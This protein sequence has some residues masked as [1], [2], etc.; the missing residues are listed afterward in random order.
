MYLHTT[1]IYKTLY[2]HIHIHT[3]TYT[4]THIYISVFFSL[5]DQKWGW[6]RRENVRVCVWVSVCVGTDYRRIQIFLCNN[7][8]CKLTVE[9]L[10]I[11]KGENHIERKVSLILSSIV[12]TRRY[13]P[14]QTWQTTL[15]VSQLLCKVHGINCLLEINWIKF[16]TYKLK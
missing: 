15:T 11:P 12:K 8:L 13:L 1:Y 10:D 14:L 4:N 5:F 6:F 9:S 16:I 7:I 3:Q 2:T